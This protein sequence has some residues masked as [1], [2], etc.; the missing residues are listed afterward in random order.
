MRWPLVWLV[1]AGLIPNALA[2]WFNLQYNRI[3]IIDPL[4]EI[5]DRFEK[6]Y[7]TINCITFPLGLAIILWAARRT[8]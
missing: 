5:M 1:L 7:W 2:G 3:A 4:P 8:Q 6:V